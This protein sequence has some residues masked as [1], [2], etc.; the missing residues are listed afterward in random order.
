MQGACGQ[1]GIIDL[2]HW[3]SEHFTREIFQELLY[4]QV[5]TYI[6]TNDVTPVKWLIKENETI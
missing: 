1:I 2:D 3:T 4:K 6:A 5:T